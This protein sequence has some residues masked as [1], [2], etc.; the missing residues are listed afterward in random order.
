MQNFPPDSQTPPEIPPFMGDFFRFFPLFFAAICSFACLGFI[1]QLIAAVFRTFGGRAIVLEDKGV[2]ASFGRGWTVFRQNI[3][4]SIILVLITIVISALISIVIAI[5]AIIIM[6][7]MMMS[8]M[9]RIFSGEGL[10]VGNILLMGGAAIIIYLITSFFGGVLLVFT[11][12]LWT[13]AY[14][15]FT[16]EKSPVP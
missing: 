6:F 1:I 9:P 2:I 7:P 12:T 11:E 5:P 15:E 10:S 13:L 16:T 4:A 14:R 8:T 3:A